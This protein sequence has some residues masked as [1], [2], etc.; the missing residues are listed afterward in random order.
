MNFRVLIGVFIISV[1]AAVAGGFWYFRT[2]DAVEEAHSEPVNAE[3]SEEN[4][5]TSV[6]LTPEK[7]RIAD[8]LLTEVVKMKLH[9]QNKVPGR[10]R[11]DDRRHIEVRSATS[12]IVTAVLVNPGDVVKTGD[13]LIELSSPEIGSARADVLQRISELKLATENRGW[14]QEICDG[15]ASLT[16][17]IRKRMPVEQIR[18]EFKS[19]TLGKN[20]EQL[21][22]AYSDLVLAESLLNAVKEN[23]QNGVVPARVVQE[24][25]NVRDNAEAGLLTAL[26]SLTYASSVSLRRADINV[27]DAE[28]RLMISRQAVRTLLGQS[29][30]CEAAGESV[31][32]RA[33]SEM[34]P[35]S[36]SLSLV[37]LRAP[38][39]GT[40]E[41]RHYSPSERVAAGDGLLTLADTSTLWVAADLRE[42]DWNALVLKTGDEIVIEPSTPDAESI[43]ARVHFVGREVDPATN[44]VPLIAVVDNTEGRL[45]PGMF[46]R[47]AV[48]VAETREALAV[49]E[50]AIQE[51]DHRTFVFSPD[52]DKDFR[53]IDIIPGLRVAGVVEV[54]SGLNTGDQVVAKG[55]FYLKSEML[56]EGEE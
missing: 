11:Y 20:R 17:A 35:E 49:P 7:L 1:A 10:L 16:G 47:V 50:S 30:T 3:T 53:R 36:E 14:E 52:G 22:S 5:R 38:F 6:S 23:A 43:S 54:I 2:T 24:R 51:H 25:T 56:L 40:I 4:I 41:R 18:E 45:R 33:D 27:Q 39:A 32:T 19:V 26:E 42:R 13:V 44:A 34:N 9:P 12:G 48:P 37:R 29:A 46:V 55:G 8:I 28:R 21:L 31:S 15:L